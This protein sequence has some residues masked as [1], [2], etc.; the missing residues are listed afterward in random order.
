MMTSKLLN[1]D[2]GR[3]MVRSVMPFKNPPWCEQRQSGCRK[4]LWGSSRVIPL[5]TLEMG[6]SHLRLWSRHTVALIA[7]LALIA[8]GLRSSGSEGLS[9]GRPTRPQRIISLSPNITEI[10][11]GVGAFK[12]VVAV[13]DFCDY[14]AA[15]QKLP[16]VGGWQTT[17]LEQVH[18][19]RPDLVILTQAQAPFVQGPLD[20]LG[21]KTLVVKG[22]TL[23]DTIEAI[24]LIGKA[25]GNEG[26]AENLTQQVISK[27]DA[28]RS[29]TQQLVRPRVLCVVDRVPGTLRDIYTA[30][31]GSFLSELI[32]I[33]GGECISPRAAEG[34]IKMSIEAVATL[35]PE[36]VIDMVQGAKGRF[37]ENPTQVWQQLSE[38]SAVREGR[39]YPIRET[40]VLHPSQFVADTA[41][42]FGKIIHPEVF[43]NESSH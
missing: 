3:T 9:A 19:L 36:I 14:P 1:E 11:D 13:S 6:N 23:Q 27:L 20:S 22:L 31:Q 26:E 34:Y 10:L 40:S 17:S 8:C 18:A 29:R 4:F 28:V 43:Q 21:F 37:A 35:N 12:R 5:H 41:R 2:L 25:T 39:I 16:R 15:T 30:T 7:L 38:I 24:G 42:S 32:E 33:A